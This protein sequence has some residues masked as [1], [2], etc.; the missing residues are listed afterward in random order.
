MKIFAISIVKNEADI[1]EQNLKDAERWADKIFVLDNGSTDG[2]WEIVQSLASE[3]IVP[4]KQ[5]NTAF[6]FGIRSQIYHNFKHLAAK[7]DWWCFRLDADEFY[8]D[9][10]R[11][12]LSKV[13]RFHHFVVSDT[14]HFRLTHE[15][16]E[17]CNQRKGIEGIRYYEKHTWSEARFF[18][19]RDNLIWSN[20]EG[21][22]KHMG[23]LHSKRIKIKHYQERSLDQLKNRIAVRIDARDNGHT[24]FKYATNQDLMS[25]IKDRNDLV[26]YSGNEDWKITGPL[27]PLYQRWYNRLIKTFLHAIRAFK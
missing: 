23:V 11:E 7:G 26:Y 13:S 27:I 24:G 5:D 20:S 1:I 12:F 2:T 10:P 8:A 15:D 9:D 3:K 14:I 16:L 6:H 19:H 17:L 18:R 25:Y 4:W 21:T 22:P